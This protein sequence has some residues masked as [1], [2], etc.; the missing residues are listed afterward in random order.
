MKKCLFSLGCLFFLFQPIHSNAKKNEIS[1][2][3]KKMVEETKAEY[4]NL[5]NNDVLASFDL[6]ENKV[7]NNLLYFTASDLWKNEMLTGKNETFDSLKELMAGK[8]RGEKRLY[9]INH[10]PSTGYILYKDIDNNNIMLTIKKESNKWV[11]AD[12]EIKEGKDIVIETTKC[13][14]QHF[15]QKM[16]DNLYP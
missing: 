15:M 12:K 16:F 3:C 1:E 5:V 6:L 2:E 13:D 11:L 4:I 9:F 10:D 8:Y 14:D 7:E